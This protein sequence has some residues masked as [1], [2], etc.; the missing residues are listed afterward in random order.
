MSIPVEVLEVE[1]LNLPPAERSRLLDRLLASLGP[2]LAWEDAWA[3]EVD[4][5]EAEI[6]AGRA[7]WIPGEEVVARL[8]AKLN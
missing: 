4:R 6:A 1:V 3:Q 8:R 5:R 2:D 7:S